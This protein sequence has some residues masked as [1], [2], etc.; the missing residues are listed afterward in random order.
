[1]SGEVIYSNVIFI[2][3]QKQAAGAKGCVFGK[4]LE[5]EENVTYSEI[6]IGAGKQ[7]NVQTESTCP[8]IPAPPVESK[9]FIP[10]GRFRRVVLVTL[11]CLC[12]ILLVLTITLG[13]LYALNKIHLKAEQV[14]IKEYLRIQKEQ[15]SE[16]HHIERNLS[17]VNDLLAKAQDEKKWLSSELEN[18][19]RNITALNNL[20]K[21]VQARQCASGWEFYNGSCYHFSEDKLTWEQS[22]YACIRDGGHLVIIE[23]HQEQ[24]FIRMKV[25]N[26]D[27]TNSYWIGMTD[28]K[29]EGVWV[30]MDNTT[31]SNNTMYWDQNNGTQVSAFPEPNNW[32]SSEDC[33]HMGVRCSGQISCWFDYGCN[34]PSKS[35]CESRSIK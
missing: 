3:N 33:A 6:T 5:L 2:Q 19:T 15:S 10:E 26:T 8:D 18:N 31:L 35:I 12:V 4:A 34:I 11:V 9:I 32:E 13:L 21:S 16:L 22:Q 28:I 14:R 23:S 17:A 7:G 20:L 25:G 29:V 27:I 30:W 1:M 24:D